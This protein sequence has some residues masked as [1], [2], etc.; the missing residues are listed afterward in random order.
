MAS[1]AAGRLAPPA[2]VHVSAGLLR[3]GATVIRRGRGVIV[4]NDRDRESIEA[5][6]GLWCVNVGH[7]CREI[8]HAAAKQ[9]NELAFFHIFND[10]TNEP[11]AKLSALGVFFGNS[12]SD[13]NY[14]AIK[15]VAL[16]NDVRGR[17]EKRKIIARWRGY[18]G[19]TVASGSLAG[20]PG[21]RR[22][23]DL[24]LPTVGHVDWPD[25]YHVPERSAADYARDLEKAILADGPETVAAFIA[26]PVKGT[27]GVL[28]PPDRYF[29]TVREVLDRYDVL[30]ILDEV[31]CGFAVGTWFGSDRFGITPDMM[32]TAKGLTSG[33]LPTTAVL[34]AD[35][36]WSVIEESSD[37]L[38]ILG[39]GFTTSG[40]RAS[41]AFANL[42]IIERENL[43]AR[44][45]ALSAQPLDRVS[46]QLRKEAA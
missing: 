20:L 23:F 38:D 8:V 19:V 28:I 17:K 45:G 39:H 32:T 30:L 26:E 7:G 2:S 18:H 13:A 44:T 6:V 4:K 41:S 31:I 22:F 9:M 36:F 10:V 33:Y 34:I 5:A 1:A 24:P 40:R 16:Y 14:T 21:M 11:I 3:D 29:R 15:Q 35:R 42:D 25:R 43:V 37:V 46:D 12:G 27:G